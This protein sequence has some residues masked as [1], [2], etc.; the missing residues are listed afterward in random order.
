VGD[1]WEK[2]R[3]ATAD[4]LITETKF[5]GSAI[6]LHGNT[7][8][9]GWPFRLIVAVGRPGNEPAIALADEFQRKLTEAGAPET[10]A[11]NAR[12]PAKTPVVD[13]CEALRWMAQTVHQAHHDGPLDVCPVNTC[14]HAREAVA[15]WRP[16]Q[17]T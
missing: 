7:T 17:E 11:D 3:F 2:V 16:R 12:Y 10:R 4:A 8:P 6:V 5:R 9:E 15:K 13:L 1:A 14:R